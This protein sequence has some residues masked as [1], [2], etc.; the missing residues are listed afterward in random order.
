MRGEAEMG[1]SYREV[2][3][4][5]VVAVHVQQL[6]DI[7]LHLLRRRGRRRLLREE[8]VS[9]AVQHA[10]WRTVPRQYTTLL[11]SRDHRGADRG[12]IEFLQLVVEP[13]LDGKTFTN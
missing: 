8:L 11:T 12:F 3:P 10:W 7:H 4:A 6:V 5:Q 9:M 2:P 1:A 13:H